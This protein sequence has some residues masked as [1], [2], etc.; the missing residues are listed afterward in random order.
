MTAAP[1]ILILYAHP[2]PH[3]SHINRRL[4]EAAR[5]VPNVRVHD[6]YETYPDFYIDVPR[7]Q[8]L[9][10]DADL[11]V[12][13]HPIQWYGMP[14]LLKQW[15]DTVLEQ[16][17]AYGDGGT[18]LRGKDYWLAVT[19]GGPHESYQESGYHRHAFAAFLPPFRQTA[20]LCGMRWLSPHIIHGAHRIDE[21]T[22]TERIANYRE[23]LATY[24]QWPE[25][26]ADAA[27]I[28]I[29]KDQPD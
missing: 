27:R 8:A 18:A 14:A 4:A 10:A 1:R 15:V 13:Q 7:E 28:G 9:L 21:A 12:F 2:A 26:E 29:T 25:L 20:D 22:M 5:S 17:W 3:R 19:T 24:P 6:L 11:A 23:R 16:G